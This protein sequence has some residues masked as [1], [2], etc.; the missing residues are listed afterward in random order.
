MDDDSYFP[1]VALQINDNKFREK[2]LRNSGVS[3][4]EMTR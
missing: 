2:R 1:Y 3:Q 4:C